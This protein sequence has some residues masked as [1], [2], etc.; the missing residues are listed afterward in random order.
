MARQSGN[1]WMGDAKI[2]GERKRVVFNSLAE[3][4]AFEANPYLT[5]KV[6][7]SVDT[8]GKLFPKWT[9][10]VYGRTKNERNAF[11]ISEELVRRLGADLPVNKIDRKKVKSLVAEL[12]AE[13][14]AKGTINTKT[15]TLSKLL[16][17]GI[18]EEVIETVP[19]IP[20]YSK[21][22]GRIRVLSKDEE[23][24]I[25]SRL[26]EPYRCFAVFLLSTGCRHG[27]AVA[28]QWADVSSDSVT[29]WRTKTDKPRTVP[30]T[31]KAKDSLQWAK[32]GL[33]IPNARNPASKLPRVSTAP[34]SYVNYHTFL[35]EW[36]RAIEAMGL[37][38]D[39]ELVP[40]AMRH[41]CAT[42][43]A[44][45]GMSELRLMQWM[46]HTNLMTT[47]RYTHLTTADLMQ[48]VAI[49]GG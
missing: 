37:G 31:Q 6:E 39:T 4:E 21:T 24:G 8:I 26:S 32:A 43:L 49:L 40:Y 30:L 27:E 47:R 15:S 41:T 16:H 10:E 20:F 14:N 2:N 18:E 36:D 38:E 33:P 25:M 3:A 19:I 23:V 22:N 12:E 5:L 48:G 44:Q 29:F 7:P 13:G 9:R 34:F 1:K 46:G 17:Y 42:R 11:R 35:N 45:G 28:I